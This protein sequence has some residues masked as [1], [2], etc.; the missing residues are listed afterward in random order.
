MWF[1][2]VRKEIHVLSSYTQLALLSF[3]YTCSTLLIMCCCKCKLV[4][5]FVCLNHPR[6]SF[7]FYCNYKIDLF[8]FFHK[9]AYYKYIYIYLCAFCCDNPW[10][11]ILICRRFGTWM[12]AKLTG[13]G[14]KNMLEGPICNGS[15]VTGWHINGS[16]GRFQRFHA[17]MSGFAFN[18]TILWDPKRWHRPTLEPIRQ[19]DT[20]NNDFQVSLSCFFF[21]YPVVHNNTSCCNMICHC[22]CLCEAAKMVIFSFFTRTCIFGNVTGLHNMIGVSSYS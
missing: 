18:S 3:V 17:E 6:S 15:Q 10:I 4:R 19:L 22:C 12:V 16:N 21:G 14:S 2:A 1:N 11:S 9:C 8:L 7:R 13:N 20:V 5:H